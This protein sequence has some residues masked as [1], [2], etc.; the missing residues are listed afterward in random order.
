MFRVELGCQL[1]ILL[2]ES[3][4]TSISLL[5]FLVIKYIMTAVVCMH[6]MFCLSI[7][8]VLYALAVVYELQCF[9]PEKNENKKSL[10][11]I[12]WFN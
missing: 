5:I 6:F 10:Y 12:I 3:V 1:V 4:V 2:I 7:G 8:I 11:R 9:T